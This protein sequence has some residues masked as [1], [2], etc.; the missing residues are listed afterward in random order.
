MTAQERLDRLPPKDQCEIMGV[1]VQ[2]RLLGVSRAVTAGEIQD[3]FS[4][5]EI[6]LRPLAMDF[7][8]EQLIA[9]AATKL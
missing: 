5:L 7:Y 3:Q 6:E 2:L 9:G 1:V 4:R 8:R